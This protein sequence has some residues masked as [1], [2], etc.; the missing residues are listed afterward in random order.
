MIRKVAEVIV[1]KQQFGISGLVTE[2][3]MH[4]DFSLNNVLMKGKALPDP[5]KNKKQ[6]TN[7][8][9]QEQQKDKQSKEAKNKEWVDLAASVRDKREIIGIDPEQMRE[10]C[11]D[12]LKIDSDPRKWDLKTM[13]MID[14]YLSDWL[15]KIEEPIDLNDTESDADALADAFEEHEKNGQTN[16]SAYQHS[17]V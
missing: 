6:A 13:R 12:V 14:Q 5:N 8:K 1:L 4:S 9:R 2:E 15:A 16:Y 11:R 7:Q 17:S 3:E 10:L